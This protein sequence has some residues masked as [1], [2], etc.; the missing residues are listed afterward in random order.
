[1]C[2]RM[3]VVQ[4]RPKGKFLNFPPGDY[5]FG[6]G[7]ECHVRP[8]SPWVSRQHCLLHITGTMAFVRDLGSSNGT[9]VNGQAVSLD[10]P[11]TP[12]DKLQIGPL[13]LEIVESSADQMGSETPPP[14]SATSS[15]TGELTKTPEA[16]RWS[17]PG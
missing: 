11:L 13:V 12:G 14:T 3:L 7:E 2:L 1:M 5:I 17:V 15:D 9:L 8:N 4:G 6:R 16:P 10:A